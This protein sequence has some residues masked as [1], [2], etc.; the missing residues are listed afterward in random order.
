MFLNFTQVS[1]SCFKTSGFGHIHRVSN[2]KRHSIVTSGIIGPGKSW[3]SIPLTKNGKPA[4]LTMHV[5][6]DDDVVVIAGSEKGKIGKVLSVYPKTGRVRVLG[7]NIVTKH[8][9]PTREG[10][11]GKINK[12]EGVL[13]Q[14]NVMHWSK[15]KQ[16]RSRMGKKI[17][18]GNKVRYLVKTG[19]V[20]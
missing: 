6:V 20:L 3:T 18:N 14:S 13:H 9:K 2:I 10:E 19:D 15:E 11:V 17:V 4:T 1:Q 8:I 12:S 7:V 5:K 16:V